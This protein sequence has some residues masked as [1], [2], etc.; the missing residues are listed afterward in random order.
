MPRTASLLRIN[1]EIVNKVLDILTHVNEEITYDKDNNLAIYIKNE[2]DNQYYIL[3]D[4][5]D[6]IRIDERNKDEIQTRTQQIKKCAGVQF[7]Y[8]PTIKGNKTEINNIIIV[9]ESDKKV[10]LLSTVIEKIINNYNYVPFQRVKFEITTNNE[11]I[12]RNQFDDIIKISSE[13]IIDVAITDLTIKGTNIYNANPEY[14]KAF[15]GSIKGIGIK[16]DGKWY[17]ISNLGKITTYNS[18]TDREFNDA[19]YRII[20]NFLD[21]NA[22]SF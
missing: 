17:L 6:E 20:V 21:A 9:L 5:I 1:P 13:G 12:I 22:I 11:N 10:K 16:L 8:Y 7:F 15:T 14:D 19:I 3:I 18:L 4:Y 2:G